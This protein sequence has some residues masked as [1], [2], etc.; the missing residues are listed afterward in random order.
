MARRLAVW[1]DQKSGAFLLSPEDSAAANLSASGQF[2][3]QRMPEADLSAALR[4]ERP[5]SNGALSDAP[6]LEETAE[7]VG[8]RHG[9]TPEG[10]V[11]LTS[12]WRKVG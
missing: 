8:F 12:T 1:I 11:T 6:S 9:P 2:N 10:V 7:P 4:K 5:T 3:K